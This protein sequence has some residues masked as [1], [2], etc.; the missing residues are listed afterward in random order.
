MLEEL[1]AGEYGAGAGNTAQFGHDTQLPGNGFCAHI[2]DEASHLGQLAHAAG[3]EAGDGGDVVVPGPVGDAGGSVDTLVVGSPV[4]R[5]T[6]VVSSSIDHF[7]QRR[8]QALDV[9]LEDGDALGGDLAHACQVRLAATV[10]TLKTLQFGHLVIRDRLLQQKGVS[11]GERFGL[12]SREGDISDVVHLAH[13]E[14]TAHD[15]GD[16]LGFT[17]HGLPHVGVE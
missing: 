3:G 13:V 15:L 1:L 12:C 4:D 6:E 5:H 9:A 14:S 11:G 16:E 17:L 8:G 2:E 10:G 7:R